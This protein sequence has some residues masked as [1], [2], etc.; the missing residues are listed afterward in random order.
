MAYGRQSQRISNN[1]LDSFT[2]CPLR[3]ITTA[4]IGD[5]LN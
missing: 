3:K 2:S 1:D 4:T 5:N